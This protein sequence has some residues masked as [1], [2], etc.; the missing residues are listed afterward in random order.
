MAATA[1]PIS[2]GELSLWVRA[3]DTDQSILREVSQRKLAKALTAPEEATLRTQGASNSLI[4]SLK[5]PTL[6]A[7]PADVA[8]TE[9]KS[10]A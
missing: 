5:A 4:Q 9:A 6:V 10:P 7:A 1:A 2:F 3:R 8:P